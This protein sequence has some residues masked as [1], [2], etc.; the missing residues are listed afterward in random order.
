MVYGVWLVWTLV[1]GGIQLEKGHPLWLVCRP[2]WPELGRL[3]L[4]WLPGLQT[5]VAVIW[6]GVGQQ[7][8]LVRVRVVPMYV[9]AL[10]FVAVA[11]ELFVVF[12]L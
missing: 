12:G 10:P 5:V 1:A 2:L 8:V 9:G 6:H 4:Q 7:P 3:V 11:V